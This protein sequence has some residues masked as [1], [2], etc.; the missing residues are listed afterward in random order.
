[1]F[2]EGGTFFRHTGLGANVRRKPG[3][4]IMQVAAKRLSTEQLPR[5]VVSDIREFELMMH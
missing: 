2:A 4:P 5:L 3:F 1:L